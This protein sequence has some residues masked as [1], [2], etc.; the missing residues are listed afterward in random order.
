VSAE[1]GRGLESTVVWA[2]AG[3]DSEWGVVLAIP[4]EALATRAALAAPTADHLVALAA[5]FLHRQ[6]ASVAQPASAAAAGRQAPLVD[7]EMLPRPVRHQRRPV[8]WERPWRPSR[9][10]VI[11]H[12]QSCRYYC[13]PG[14]KMIRRRIARHSYRYRARRVQLYAHVAMLSEPAPHV[15]AHRTSML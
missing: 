15:T 7:R 6:A 8:P 10:T 11:R 4:A 14:A 9:R 12:H 13:A 3:S 1:V 5:A 2:A